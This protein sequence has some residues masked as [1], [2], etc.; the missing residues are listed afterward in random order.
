MWLIQP[1]PHLPYGWLYMS[2]LCVGS[3]TNDL[4]AEVSRLQAEVRRLKSEAQQGKGSVLVS[5]KK[6]D[7]QWDLAKDGQADIQHS[8]PDRC[9]ATSVGT[10]DT[11][12]HPRQPAHIPVSC[13]ALRFCTSTAPFRRDCSDRPCSEH[14][15]G[16]CQRR[17]GHQKDLPRPL[18]PST[19][20][21]SSHPTSSSP[22]MLALT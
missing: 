16:G 11:E 6:S 13:I 10:V 9:R 17:P 21:T 8:K 5:S 15:S 2:A 7:S 22:A 3:D 18:L 4:Q 20:T 19:A 12:P 1:L 14:N